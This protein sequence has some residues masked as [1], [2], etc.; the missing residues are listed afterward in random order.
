MMTVDLHIDVPWK[1]TRYNLRD[2]HRSPYQVDIPRMKAGG[3]DAAFFALYL[4]DSM[5]DEVGEEASSALIDK[6][7]AWIKHADFTDIA[8]FKGL[9]GG[10]LIHQDLYRLQA[11]R[12]AGLRYLTLTHNHNTAWA[13]S[14]TDVPRHEG[15]TQFGTD[16]VAECNRLGVLVDVSH[17]S[18]AT[19]L[20]AAAFST[21]PIIASHSGCR[22]LLDHPRNLSDRLIKAVAETGGLIGVPF[23]RRFIGP[24]ASGVADHI[25]HIVQR[26]GPA[27][28]GIGSDLDGAVMADDIPNVSVWSHVVND[29]LADRGYTDADIAA[30][31]GGNIL[32]LLD[33]VDVK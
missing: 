10:R 19:C 14:S 33:V 28:V 3:L 29:A 11:L 25:D 7:I 23:A 30:I 12:E 8:I 26:V 9:E 20:D 24:K 6:Q 32:R 31:A 18:D 5:Q 15:L 2:L 13:D 27:H 21:K 4:S 17:A 16:V 1:F 22:A